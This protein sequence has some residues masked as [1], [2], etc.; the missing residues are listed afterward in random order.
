[1]KFPNIFFLCDFFYAVPIYR[2]KEDLTVLTRGT[3]ANVTK[4]SKMY[5]FRTDYHRTWT[6][7]CYSLD[8]RYYICS[9]EI[10]YAG[11]PP[12]EA[13]T[14]GRSIDSV[15]RPF[16]PSEWVDVNL[17]V[18]STPR[19]SSA[20]TNLTVDTSLY[21]ATIPTSSCKLAIYRSLVLQ[22]VSLTR[23]R[24]FRHAGW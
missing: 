1:M 3:S 24:S 11:S 2:T 14:R 10:G 13:L 20:L 15:D 16:H 8:T 22:A 23:T 7:R 9:S 6:T 21:P 4:R 17:E 18:P 12:R 19:A 5:Y